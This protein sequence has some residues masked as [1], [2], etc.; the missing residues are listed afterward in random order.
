M[1]VFAINLSL[2][3][4]ASYVVLSYIYGNHARP[5][6]ITN[7]MESANSPHVVRLV[8]NTTTQVAITTLQIRAP[9]ADR[10]RSERRGRGIK[11]TYS[12]TSQQLTFLDLRLFIKGWFTECFIEEPNYIN[13]PHEGQETESS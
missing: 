7:D 9:I 10:I 3:R 1:F 11:W 6:G 13:R 8:W 12:R 2:L 4:L 5:R